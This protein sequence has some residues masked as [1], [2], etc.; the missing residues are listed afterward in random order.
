MDHYATLGVAKNATPEDIKRAYRRLAAQHH[1]D[2]GG[3]TAR[4]Q[5]IQ[6][7]YDVL[8]DPEK[9]AQ[10]DNPAPHVHNF[11]FG[12]GAGFSPFDDIISQFMRQQRQAIYSTTVAVT[13]EQIAQNQQIDIYLNTPQGSRVVQLTP[14][15]AVDTGQNMRY[16]GIIPD[17]ILQVTFV[18]QPHPEFQR[19][20]LDIYSTQWVNVFQIILGTSITVRTILGTELEV[21]VPPRF[22]PGTHLRIPGRGLSAHGQSG[23]H[24]VL[25][26]AQIPDMISDGLLTSIAQE[27]NV[28]T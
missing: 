9:R 11:P 14:P 1:P 5:E 15:A 3:D 7:A 13:L 8:G 19:Q 23:N 24:F 17:A 16:E 22:R 18:V 27:Y 26:Q 20:G 21:R 2:R 25:I 28:N 12:A 6:Q 4:F 10:Y